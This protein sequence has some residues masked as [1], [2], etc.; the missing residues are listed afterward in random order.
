M[1]PCFAI[2]CLA[3]KCIC[4]AIQQSLSSDRGSVARPSW[5]AVGIAALSWLERHGFS[6]KR[7]QPRAI[8]VA[9]TFLN[10]RRAAA[11]RSTCKPAGREMRHKALAVSRNMEAM[12]N[13]DVFNVSIRK[14]LKTLGVSAPAG[15][16]EKAVRQGL[17]EGKLK[18]NERLQAMAV[19][20][21][22]EIGLS[23]EV[24]GE[25]ELE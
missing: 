15:D 25:I 2:D 19:V 11:S 20:T 4:F 22:G 24:K 3:R 6:A 17:A 18:G 7:G 16:V 12:M 8:V 21:L 23:H 9:P 5:A 1:S 14:F 10:S 13:E